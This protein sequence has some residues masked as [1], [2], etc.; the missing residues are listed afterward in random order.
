MA[1]VVLDIKIRVVDPIGLV[2]AQGHFHQALPEQG[3]IVSG[4]LKHIHDIFQAHGTLGC[5]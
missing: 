4:A 1:N 5:A 2:E 3:Y